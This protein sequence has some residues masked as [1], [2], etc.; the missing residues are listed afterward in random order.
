[1]KLLLLQPPVEDFYDTDLRLQPLGLCYLKATVEKHFPQIEVTVRDFHHGW[2]RK[3]VALPLELSYLKPY[4]CWPDR[5]PFSTFYSYFHF[6]ASFEVIANEV[7]RLKPDL[8]GISS[9]F[10]SYFR[11]VL[12]IAEAIRNRLPVPILLG[13]SH[14]SAE[15]VMMLQNPHVDFVIRGEGER[16]LVEFLKAWITDG[17]LSSVPNLGWKYQGCLIFNPIKENYPVND[18]PWPDFSDLDT[19]QYCFE[20]RPMSFLITSRS[21]PHRCTFCSVHTTF[22]KAYRRRSVDDVLQ[23]IIE[24]YSKGIRVFDFEDDNLTFYLRE[25]KQL[26]AALIQAFP[27]KNVQF[28]AMNGI[29]YLSL[30]DELLE[31]MKTAGFTHL[32]LALVSSDTTVRETAKRPHTVEKYLQVVNKAF[33]LGFKIVS[34]QILG[35][36]RESLDSM[37]QTLVFMA[38]QPVLQGASIFYL[39]PNSPIARKFPLVGEFDVFKSRS[40]A[41][42]FESRECSRDQLYTLLVTTRIINFL[43]GIDIPEGINTISVLLERLPARGGRVAL[44]AMLLTKLLETGC[45]Y[46]AG[47]DGLRSMKRFDSHL[48]FR[49]WNRLEFIRTLSGCRLN[50]DAV[51][52]RAEVKPVSIGRR[53]GHG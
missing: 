19:A 5:S 2:G 33:Q 52:S 38:Q 51:P 14:V 43:K 32:N 47:R 45:L 11:E 30:D 29:S 13:G 17:D 26:C 41:M 49:I 37:M 7:V 23:E 6:G 40:T 34:Y 16:P 9:L 1:M 39:T 44:G 10:S 48:F 35:L 12:K 22:G 4:Y 27:S 50:I 18:L 21:C 3:T 28:L 24:R 20:G 42:A 15:P 8:V 31:L 25:M 46:A 36:P 53:M